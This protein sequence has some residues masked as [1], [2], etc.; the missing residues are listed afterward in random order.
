M[1]LKLFITGTDTHVGK[2]YISAGLLSAFNK[3]GCET[4]GIKPVASGCVRVE[5]Q[6]RSEDTL[7]LQ[8]HSSIKLP[9]DE[10]TPFAFEP[11]I[12]PHIAAQQASRDL[13]VENMNQQLKHALHFPTDVHIIEGCGGWHVP[14]NAAE[15]MA[16][17]VLAN[18]LEVILV[19]GVR[20]GCINHSL[21]TY[22]AMQQE[23][24]KI[25]GW[26]ANCVDPTMKNK[27][28]NIATL[29]EWLPTPCLAVV[30]H[31]IQPETVIDAD[32]LIS[33]YYS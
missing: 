5:N 18:E 19:V 15:T 33:T 4:L 1:T 32:S 9:H 16:D 12:A 28:E 14:L 7:I 24:A 23:G 11:A 3:I 17:F 13:S 25:K 10:V 22:R 26:I 8:Q 30:D 31:G 6:L 21:L 29:Q 27:E 20:L 2:T